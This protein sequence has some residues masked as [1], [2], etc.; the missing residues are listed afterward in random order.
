MRER[1]PPFINNGREPLGVVVASSEMEE[2]GDTRMLTR[3]RG[4]GSEE[5]VH[6]MAKV[7][8]EELHVVVA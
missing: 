2:Y 8:H 3:G 5:E 4:R 7:G 6:D 1:A